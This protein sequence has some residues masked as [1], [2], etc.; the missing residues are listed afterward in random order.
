MSGTVN[1][2]AAKLTLDIE[3][4]VSNA[5]EAGKALSGMNSS[6]GEAGKSAKESSG[7]L[8]SIK[9]LIFGFAGGQAIVE[10]AGKAF[11]FLKDNITDSVAQAQDANQ[12]F[13][14]QTAVLKSTNDAVGLSAAQLDKMATS[15]QGTTTFTDDAVTSA[16]NMLLTFT[17]I[18]KQVF[19]QATK[20]TLDLATAMKEDTKSAAVQL[21]KA[22]NDPI[23]GISALS[24]VGVTFDAA[25]K[26]LITTYVEHG[27]KAKAQAI[28]LQE[29]QREFGGSATAAG[30]TFAGKM[31]ILSHSF[32]DAKKEL[33]NFIIEGLSKLQPLLL[34][35]AGVLQG[36]FTKGLD[37]AKDKIGQLW[38][39]TAPLR[40]QLVALWGDLQMLGGVIVTKLIPP[41]GNLVSSLLGPML[42]AFSG[43]GGSLV[44][45]D[46]KGTFIKIGS[47]VTNAGAMIKQFS[48]WLK[49]SPIPG[50]LQQIVLKGKDLIGFLGT[51]GDLF[52][53]AGTNGDI[54][55]DALLGIGAAIVAFKTAS[56]IQSLLTTVPALL[57][58][59]GAAW[60][61]ATGF[62]AL[63]WPI[64]AIA[65][66]VGIVVL[67]FKHWW[68][69]NEG[70]RKAIQNLISGGL[71]IFHDILRKIT[72]IVQDLAGKFQKW[73][74]DV[75]T[76]AI[77]AMKNVADFLGVVLPAAFDILKVVLQGLQ[78][79]WN[80]MWPALSAVL[81]GVWL[82]I[83]GVVEIATS[84]IGGIIKVFLDVIGGNWS[85]AWTDIQEM[86]SGVWDGI[87]KILEGAL[88]WIWGVISNIF[89]KILAW[90]GSFFGGLI[91]NF[92]KWELNI[93][94]GI[95]KWVTDTYTKIHDT[96][97]S[98]GVFLYGKLTE[99]ET[100][101]A[102]KAGQLKDAILK[103]FIDAKNAIGGI[104]K[105]LANTAIR[106]L[107]VAIGGWESMAN[108]MASAI[109]NV[110]SKIGL[111]NVVPHIHLPRIPF[112]ASGTP[113]FK[114]GPAILGE[115]GPELAFLPGGTSVLSNAKSRAFLSS[116]GSSL[117]IGTRGGSSGLSA[118][119]SSSVGE[120]VM[121]HSTIRINEKQL[122]DVVGPGIVRALRTGGGVKS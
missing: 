91:G 36:L 52:L 70:F 9:N 110:T 33:G 55:R 2:I 13:A 40:D 89:L 72:P 122:I 38:T 3:N 103:P 95:V 81:Q 53:S 60:T 18:G 92:I 17:G 63:T 51:V 97:V 8:G 47:A 45:T 59:A 1:E 117:S 116:S 7:P 41:I 108:G 74:S 85:Q 50:I 121:V 76:R 35:A 49:S 114:G 11:D 23:K 102:N 77:P 34:G 10:G 109:D 44:K 43:A 24:R 98:I 62:L 100:N 4:F 78:Q 21:G 106:G 101:I 29:L 26:K 69:T 84:I 57:T 22:L 6:L 75:E 32:D 20:A 120:N 73:W 105:D 111:G 46:F 96:F 56:L 37:L 68:D 25:Q 42:S 12:A 71:N 64:L 65:A 107:N 5:K 87:M 112:L 104:V 93:V 88:T 58:T 79:F 115:R 30:N 113:N 90:L 19:P 28:I 86:F 82:I 67:L 15:L 14:Q 94:K 99:I 27:Q 48:D 16:Q 61:A 54:A 31:T 66:V 80:F 83:Q 39:A 118:G 119:S